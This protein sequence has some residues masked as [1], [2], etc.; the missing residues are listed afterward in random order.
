[1]VQEKMKDSSAIKRIYQASPFG[2]AIGW[3]LAVWRQQEMH[4]GTLSFGTI[5]VTVQS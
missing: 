1:M 5:H 2:N 3:I 4:A